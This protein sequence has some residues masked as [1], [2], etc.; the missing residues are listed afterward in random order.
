MFAGLGGFHA[1]LSKLGMKCVFASEISPYLQN[2]YEINYGI[3]PHGDI[4]KIEASQVPAHDV[5]CAGFPCQSFS[6]A[7]KKK[8]AKCPNSGKLIDDVARIAKHH[9]P[10]Y[11]LLENVPNILTI[12][13]GAF[14]CHVVRAFSGMGYHVDHRIYSPV[15]FGIPQKRK[16]V[17]ISAALGE[18]K[19]RWPE[20]G[21][22]Q[23]CP[24]SSLLE[25][26]KNVP[27]VECV[28]SLE[29]AKVDILRVWQQIIDEI[30]ELTHNS[31]ISPE[32]GATY[33][34][35]KINKINLRQ[36]RRYKGAWG[37]SLKGCKTWGEAIAR[38]PRYIDPKTHLPPEWL[39]GSIEYSR[40]VYRHN[41]AFFNALKKSLSAA[42]ASWQKMQ[43][44]GDRDKRVIRNHI[45]QF[46]ASGIRV[47]KPRYAPSLV[48]MTPTQTPI[49][50]KTLMYLSAREAA[51]LQGL[52]QI[53]AL[54]DSP[55]PA[56]QALGNAVN[57]KIVS[58][59][60]KVAFNPQP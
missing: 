14:W 6:L 2:L 26:I 19:V 29:V 41:P 7:G 36:I 27:V 42:P 34:I 58:E 40:K 32:F 59:I 20:K 55:G 57:V 4:R 56:F 24:A 52:E 18:N 37:V 48:A 50:G 25:Y 53:K 17:F 13:G 1:S 11:V 12:E 10:K 38:L 23:A 33:P 5:L 44:Q 51:S 8:G 46:R 28:R 16:R 30:P 39:L 31:V 35:H 9:K 3:R 15:E 43:W 22:Q 54:P 49:I 47:I 60:A 21:E 45:I